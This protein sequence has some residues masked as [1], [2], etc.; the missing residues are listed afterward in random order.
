M[1]FVLWVVIAFS[2]AQDCP[3]WACDQAKIQK[4]CGRG[5]V[6]LETG[7]DLV[8]LDEIAYSQRQA[9]EVPLL[10]TL[11]FVS[12]LSCGSWCFSDG[13]I[14]PVLLVVMVGVVVVAAAAAVAVVVLFLLLLLLLFFSIF[15]FFVSVFLFLLSFLLFLLY[16]SLCLFCFMMLLLS[17]VVVAGF[18]SKR[19]AMCKS[20]E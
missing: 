4:M 2:S 7:V 18:G 13:V 20:W 3:S 1:F 10:S 5:C 19:H 8:A 12:L 17:F 16:P 9:K 6:L 11:L 15:C 14:C